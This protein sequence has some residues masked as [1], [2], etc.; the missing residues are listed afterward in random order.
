VRQ[1]RL[2]II[3]L[4]GV[5]IR[6]LTACHVITVSV[7]RVALVMRKCSEWRAGEVE[8]LGEDGREH[9]INATAEEL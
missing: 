7:W 6:G 3:V 9:E 1:R 8:V 4:C 5:R 2:V